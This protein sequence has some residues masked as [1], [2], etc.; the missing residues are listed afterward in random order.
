ML[1]VDEE[2]VVDDDEEIYLYSICIIDVE[3]IA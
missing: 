2:T 3:M 1:N